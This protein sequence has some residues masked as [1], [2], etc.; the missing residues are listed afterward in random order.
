MDYQSSDTFG[1]DQS[2][3][4]KLD[5]IESKVCEIEC[6]L[7][8]LP[9]LVLPSE[10]VDFS[11]IYQ[12]ISRALSNPNAHFTLKETKSGVLSNLENLTRA[13]EGIC[14]FE[15]Y[16][17]LRYKGEWR[18]NQ[19]NGKGLIEDSKGN[20]YIG[21]F[22]NGKMSGKG[23]LTY[24]TGA[25]F[26]GSFKSGQKSGPG[27]L[28]FP[29]EDILLGIWSEDQIEGFGKYLGCNSY[30]YEGEF[31]KGFKSGIGLEV[32]PETGDKYIGEFYKGR[33]EGIGKYFY[34]SG[35]VYIGEFSNGL[36][37]GLGKII[38]KDF[39]VVSEFNFDFV[40]KKCECFWN[41]GS[42]FFGIAKKG[43]LV[44]GVVDWKHSSF[45]GEWKNGVVECG[46]V[47]RRNGWY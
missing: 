18:D 1:L 31:S 21:D 40:G 37:H 32:L 42:R 11:A 6:R 2:I 38:D 41:D 30:I 26:E 15:S 13:P 8:D 36:K 45:V 14:H 28:S 20:S 7:N 44:E 12:N 27:K 46:E 10:S 33:F 17:G 19:F 34:S 35:L 3:Y 5:Q 47:F 29:N 43:K 39:V 16:T 4:D 22:K 24:S 25:T 9:D 23:L